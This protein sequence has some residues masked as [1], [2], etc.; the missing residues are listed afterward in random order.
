MKKLL[1]KDFISET[2]KLMVSK[3]AL[4][5]FCRDID[6]DSIRLQ[7]LKG[8]LYLK[9]YVDGSFRPDYSEFSRK[10]L[11]YLIECEILDILERIFW[12]GGL[13]TDVIID[14]QYESMAYGIY[15]YINSLTEVHE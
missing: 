3:E 5:K 4:N 6:Y 8:K 2:T 11:S 10:E 9:F 13:E 14:P 15:I 7:N 12:W 1:L